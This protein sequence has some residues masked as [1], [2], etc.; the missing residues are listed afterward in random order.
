MQILLRDLL[1]A[2][3]SFVWFVGVYNPLASIV[4]LAIMAIPVVTLFLSNEGGMFVIEEQLNI[5]NYDMDIL[6]VNKK[7][8]SSEKPTEISES[9]PAEEVFES[10]AKQESV[11][12]RN[13]EKPPI[14]YIDAWGIPTVRVTDQS[15]NIVTINSDKPTPFESDF[16]RG[17]LVFMMRTEGDLAKYNK[18][19]G[20]FKG[21]QR[22]FEIQI[23]VSGNAYRVTLKFMRIVIILFLLYF[24]FYNFVVCCINLRVN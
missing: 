5:L 7:Q 13:Q 19:E 17:E 9:G 22:R 23:Q 15:G 16:F 11:R 8:S 4:C 24:C 21:R 10:D 14:S 18:Y 20:H 12:N 1:F 3:A 6:N 2:T